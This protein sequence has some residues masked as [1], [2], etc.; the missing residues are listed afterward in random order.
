MMIETGRNKQGSRHMLESQ[1][2]PG[3]FRRQEPE[4]MRE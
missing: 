2:R 1:Q 4:E 3:K